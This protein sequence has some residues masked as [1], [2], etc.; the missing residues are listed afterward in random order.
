MIK[1]MNRSE[2]KK[3][4]RSRTILKEISFYEYMNGYMV[5]IL[6]LIKIILDYLP[7]IAVISKKNFSTKTGISKWYFSKK[8]YGSLENQYKNKFY[9]NHIQNF[10]RKQ[11]KQEQS[12]Y[13]YQKNY[14]NNVMV[15]CP[16]L[17]I[18]GPKWRI[19]K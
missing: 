16:I 13:D 9:H 12:Q 15:N 2:D 10:I 11:I 1:D 17:S 14:K 4:R 19:R 8:I 18:I 7:G 6:Y 3:L 5:D